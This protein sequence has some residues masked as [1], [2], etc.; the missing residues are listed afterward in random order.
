MLY[1]VL[2]LV[3]LVCTVLDVILLGALAWR[4]SA[5][6][7]QRLRQAGAPAQL[8]FTPGGGVQTYFEL[9]L[10]PMHRR[11]GDRFLSI[12]VWAL[13]LSVAVGLA[14]WIA[15]WLIAP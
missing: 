4:L 11:I 1:G 13:R 15:T 10:S 8:A 14:A 5:L 6:D 9:L 3:N 12:T 7:R 2:F